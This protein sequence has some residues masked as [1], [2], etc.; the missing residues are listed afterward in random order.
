MKNQSNLIIHED[1]YTNPTTIW[2]DIALIKLPDKVKCT[3]K[4]KPVKL[5]VRSDAEK[6][7]VGEEIRASG[8]G[9]THDSD[10]AITDLLR[11]VDTPVLE[12]KNCS[13]YY[14]PGSILSTH[15]CMNT[16]DAKSACNGDSGGPMT[17]KG[18]DIQIGL[19]SFGQRSKCEKGVPAVFTRISYYLDW[20]AEKTGLDV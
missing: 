11:F 18:T 14:S 10:K 8:W 13:D 4:V 2:N 19:T 12:L 17:L 6:T 16:A 7:Y 20:I 15:V 1:Y 9:L 5:A 3:D